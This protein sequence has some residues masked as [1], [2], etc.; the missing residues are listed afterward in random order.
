MDKTMTQSTTPDAIA[1]LAAILVRL[2]SPGGCPWD[3]EQTH[4]SLKRFLI[5]ECGELLDAFDDGDDRAIMDELGDVLLQVVFHAQ[6]AAEEGRFNLQDV[7]RSEC[8]KMIRRHPHVFGDSEA[9]TAANVIDQ[10]ERIK[11]DERGGDTPGS[12][13][14]GVPRHLPALHRAQRLQGKADKAGIEQPLETG[15]ALAELRGKLDELERLPATAPGD[16]ATAQLGG[17]LFAAVHL[18]RLRGV[19][20]EDA[21]QQI[22]RNREHQFAAPTETGAD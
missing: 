7:A 10:W 20:A 18:C 8:E 11:R 22:L 21:L 19:E 6:I 5:E 4:E 12:P 16:A 3:R 1:E 9:A 17:I 13:L 14:R 15:A 2:R